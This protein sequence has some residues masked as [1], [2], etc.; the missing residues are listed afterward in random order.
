MRG[1]G[2]TAIEVAHIARIELNR[3]DSKARE[4]RRPSI[5]RERFCR[6]HA[7]VKWIGIQSSAIPQNSE[8]SIC[9]CKPECSSLSTAFAHRSDIHRICWKVKLLGTFFNEFSQIHGGV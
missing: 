5:G 2:I 7:E 9:V 4:R 1:P 8:N 6:K 3:L